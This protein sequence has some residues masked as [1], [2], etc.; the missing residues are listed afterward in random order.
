LIATQMPRGGTTLARILQKECRT[1]LSR[2]AIPGMDYCLNPYTGCTHACAYCYASF[3]KRFC[4]IEDKWGSFVQVKVNFADRL[5]SQLR[6]ARPGR[7][8]LS[9]VTD[10]YQPVEQR[11]QLTR[12]CLNLLADSEMSVSILTKSDLVLRDLPLLKQLPGVD[13]G[14][15]ITTADPEVAHL[16][17]PGAP[18]PERRFAALAALAEAGIDTWIFIAPVIPGIGDTEANLASILK[19][20]A[21][22][23]VRE[24][25]YDPLNFYPTAVSNLNAL[26]RRRWPGLLSGFQAA[27]ADPGAY[28]DRL[29]FQA[30]NL[31]PFYGFGM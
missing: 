15:T 25:D 31:W 6:R 5:A 24:V 4:G 12:S 29:R 16:L 11:Y 3:M 9:S 20:A 10:P 13:V 23:G 1:A 7:V 14:F 28:H 18:E 21:Q 2:C 27:C 19:R 26:F 22:S 17:E 8:T 30:E